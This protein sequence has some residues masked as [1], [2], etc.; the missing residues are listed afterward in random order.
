MTKD[1]VRSRAG[2]P[3]R[4]L[5]DRNGPE[6]DSPEQA[7]PCWLYPVGADWRY[8]C[9]GTDARVAEISTSLN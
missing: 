4:V 9:F 5:D 8:V 2:D 1:D 6:P 3:V 7:G